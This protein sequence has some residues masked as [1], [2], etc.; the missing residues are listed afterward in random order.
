[1]SATAVALLA[2]EVTTTVSTDWLGWIVLA[3]LYALFIYGRGG[4]A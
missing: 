3:G 2:G 1:M 4:G